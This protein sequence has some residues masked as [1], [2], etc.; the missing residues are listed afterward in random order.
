[1][2]RSPWFVLVF[3]LS[4]SVSSFAYD[5]T[6]EVEAVSSSSR[7]DYSELSAAVNVDVD[8]M[9]EERSKPGDKRRYY[10]KPT[11]VKFEGSLKASPKSG[12]F[13]LVYES[14]AVWGIDPMP[15][16]SH[17]AYIQTLG[18]VVVPVYVEASAADSILSSL[19]SEKLALE[20]QASIKALHIYDYERGPRFIVMA[21][22]VLS[23]NAASNT[24]ASNAPSSKN[25][26]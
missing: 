14:M 24:A 1:M 12:D 25:V 22:S 3:I 6:Q 10:L 19:K 20:Q 9:I 11:L 2:F 15:K 4:I 7:S 17:S 21:F 8:L 23:S 13:P 16:V 5:A 18:G 26:K